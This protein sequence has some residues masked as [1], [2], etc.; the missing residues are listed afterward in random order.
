M[1][2][3]S[4]QVRELLSNRETFATTLLTIL[5]DTY[6]EQLDG[7]LTELLSWSPETFQLQLEDDFSVQIPQGN[8][9]K[10]MAAVSVVSSNA[11][12]KSLPQFITICNVL[13]GAEVE[14]ETFDPADAAEVAWG[15]TEALLLSPP[16]DDDPEPFS[17]EIRGYIG[18]VVKE[19]GMLRPP[20]VLRLGILKNIELDPAYDF[21]DDPVMY[22][23]LW[24]NQADKVEDINSMVRTRLHDLVSELRSLT[25]EHGTT[26]NLP[27]A[28]KAS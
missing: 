26:D 28:M 2:Q 8:L 5:I 12:Y 27:Q 21:S 24:K 14:P 17:D 4:P 23:A 3:D 20:D 22:E 18:V 13:S 7:G 25:L 16:T 19:A 6:A 10:I 1:P 11:F 9:D 15:V